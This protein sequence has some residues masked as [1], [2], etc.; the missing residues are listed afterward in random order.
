[1]K[2]LW[3][4]VN[5]SNA[6][7]DDKF[8]MYILARTVLFAVLGIILWAAAGKKYLPGAVMLLCFAG[9]PAMLGGVFG[10]ILYLYNHDFK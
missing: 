3:K 9:Y 5:R 2:M 1:M 6:S 7:P 8:R 4:A 10:G